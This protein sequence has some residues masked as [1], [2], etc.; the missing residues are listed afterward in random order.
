MENQKKILTRVQ[1]INWHY[2]ENERISFHGSTLVSGENTAGKSTILDAIQLVL[3]TNTRRFNVAANEKGNRSLKGYVRCKIGN[4]G[5]TYLRKDTVPANVA[6]EFYEEKGNRYFVIGVHMLSPDEE[7]KVITRWYLEECRLEDLS[8]RVE[9]RAALAEE[10][11][12]NHRKISYIEQ[13]NAARDRFKRRL[14]NLDDKFFD[15]IPKSLA[16]K[17]MDNVKEFINKFVLSEERVDVASLRENIETLSELEGILE[18]SRRQQDALE[19]ILNKYGEIE[20]KDRGI[21]INE[22]LLK[23]ANRDAAKLEVEELEGDI[24]VKSQAMAS[25]QELCEEL[26]KQIRNLEEQILAI[27]VDIQTNQS[28]KLLE[29]ARSRISELE[30]DIR[31]K[32]ENEEKLKGLLAQLA[33][34]LRSLEKLEYKPVSR[35]ELELLGRA[36]E[37]LDRGAGQSGRAEKPSDGDSGQI[38][39]EETANRNAKAS[40]TEKLETFFGKEQKEIEERWAMLTAQTKA[41]SEEIGKSQERLKNLEKRI[42]PYPE[43]AARLKELVEKEFARRGIHSNVYFLSELLEIT[44]D[45]WNN[46]VEGYLHTQKFYLVVEPEHYDTALEVYARNR[47]AIHTAGIINSRRLPAEQEADRDSLAYVVRSENRYAKAYANYILGRVVRCTDVHD[48]EKH[49]IAITPDCMLYQGYVVRHLNPRDYENPFIGQYA[50]R[51]QIQ[52]VRRDIEDKTRERSLLREKSKLH[53]DVLESARKVNLEL[54]RMYMDAPDQLLEYRRQ[55]VQARAELKE[56]ES[57]PTLIELNLKLEAKDGERAERTR[58]KDRLVE[59]TGRLR[60]HVEISRTNMAEKQEAYESLRDELERLADEE[61]MAYRDAQEKYLQNRRS[62][63]AR[64]IA[65]NFV[66]QKAQLTREKDELVNGKGGLLALQMH[67]NQAFTL[68]FVTGLTAISE[69]REALQKLRGVEIVR[70]EEKL[71]TAKEDCEQIFRSDF[72]SKM[73]ENIESAR[74]EFRSLNRALD[75][76]YYGDDSY[77][78]KISFDKRKEGLYRMITS[79]NNQEG[80]NLW[81]SAFEAEYRDEMADLF[82]KLMT[83]DD[84]G[85]KIVEE[86]TDYRSYLDY[87]IEIHKK[88][89]SVQRFSDI[90]GEKSG[91]ETQVPYY[92]AIAASFY[93]LYRYGNSVRIMLLDEAFDKMDDERIQSMMDFF[94][95]LDLQVILATPPAKIEIIG[96]K[97]GT[98]LT[99]IRVGQNSIVEEYDL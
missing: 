68:D 34:Y 84:S 22:L 62:K 95:G 45:T 27:N 64:T 25:N 52:N 19:D 61:G 38:Q 17:P 78:F 59:E 32:Q 60:N 29:K 55:M 42:L 65:E 23:L 11:R 21:L 2:F 13:K 82:A 12:V 71:K 50:Y 49:S 98:I 28:N 7:S 57:D 14:G 56:A 15:I 93:Q 58:E 44:D 30:K 89:G 86:Y 81:T 4:V 40:V 91:S 73:K 43:Y 87:D 33:A 31:D 39:I 96:E 80:M 46:A 16:F 24:R 75:S 63:S 8:F 66:R 47:A 18:R 54:I 72:L 51:V 37:D 99:A 76:I 67:Y 20:D 6:L 53:S 35:S 69:Y 83:K 77:R 9:G 90:Y 1:L 5:E 3:T 88:D 79:E 48:L 26:G 74:N 94:N 36:S 10:F 70:Y 97:V 92:V 41:V 85:Q